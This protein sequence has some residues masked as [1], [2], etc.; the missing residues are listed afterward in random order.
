M[1]AGCLQN[2]GEK[3]YFLLGATMASEADQTFTGL[4]VHLD[5][6]A[7]SNCTFENCTL[8]YS[9][10]SFVLE[11]PAFKNCKLLLDGGAAATVAM[12]IELK[13]KCPELVQP[14]IEQISGTI[15]EADDHE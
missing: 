10:T 14:Y 13:D 5:G 9:G 2:A 7:F 1:V 4:T 6:S 15:V 11:K 8:V 12:L 3:K